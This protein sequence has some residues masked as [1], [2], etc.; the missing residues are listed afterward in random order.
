MLIMVLVMA[1]ILN[2]IVQMTNSTTTRLAVLVVTRMVVMRAIVLIQLIIISRS[3][4]HTHAHAHIHRQPDTHKQTQTQTTKQTNTHTTT[5]PHNQPNKYTQATTQTN[6]EANRQTNT[7]TDTN[8]HTNTHTQQQTNY[9]TKG[10]T[11]TTRSWIIEQHDLF[12]AVLI[13]HIRSKNVATRCGASERAMQRSSKFT[14]G[15]RGAVD[16]SMDAA[17]PGARPFVGVARGQAKISNADPALP[18]R[19]SQALVLTCERLLFFN[20][21]PLSAGGVA[22]LTARTSTVRWTTILAILASPRQSV[23]THGVATRPAILGA[24]LCHARCVYCATMFGNVFEAVWASRSQ[25]LPCLSQVVRHG[26]K[27]A[28]D[29]THM[30]RA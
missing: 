17:L 6:N 25:S 29:R 28:R 13:F 14:G 27:C 16:G 23:A 10:T 8:E 15:R 12:F 21:R 11:A 1:L 20:A 2:T 5:D 9:N 19:N 30:F 22:R 7:H 24:L 3:N 26:V 4:T 18:H